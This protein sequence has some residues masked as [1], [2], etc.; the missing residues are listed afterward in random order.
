M[1]EA[2]VTVEVEVIYLNLYKGR[3]VAS[4]LRT[5]ESGGLKTLQEPLRGAEHPTQGARRLLEEVAGPTAVPHEPE[6]VGVYRYK[7]RL[8]HGPILTLSYVVLG[9]PLGLTGTWRQWYDLDDPDLF[10]E[11]DVRHGDTIREARRAARRLLE[12]KPVAIGMLEHPDQP[13][14][15]DQLK[16][17]YERVRGRRVRIDQ[18]NFRRKV[19]AARNF[20]VELHDSEA[21][22]LGEARP[23]RQP[24]WYRAGTATELNPPIR[25]DPPSK[26][27]R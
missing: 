17:V 20:V 2:A 11:N 1:N 13:F 9:R 3:L 27:R 21:E 23:G 8:R 6:M 4:C 25:F 7:D 14:K 12:T 19:E 10:V 15:I 26:Q 24:K 22:S 18:T 5:S 16:E